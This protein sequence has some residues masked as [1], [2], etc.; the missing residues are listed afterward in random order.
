MVRDAVFAQFN[1]VKKKN[2]ESGKQERVQIGTAGQFPAEIQQKRKKLILKMK[3][4]RNER[5]RSN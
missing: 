5:K 1:E 3:E 2:E 4:A